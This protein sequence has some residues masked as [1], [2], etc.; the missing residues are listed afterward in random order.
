MARRTP[1]LRNDELNDSTKLTDALFLSHVDFAH[2][3]LEAAGCAHARGDLA[4]AMA[5]VVRHFRTRKGPVWPR[6]MAHSAWLWSSGRGS[7]V[8]RANLW[9][10]DKAKSSWFPFRIHAFAADND[11]RGHAGRQT[12]VPDLLTAYDETGDERYLV[13]MMALMRRVMDL[14]PFALHPDFDNRFPYWAPD[15]DMMSDGYVLMRWFDVLQHP[16]FRGASAMTDEF[17]AWML[18]RMWFQGVQYLRSEGSRYRD[19]NHHGFEY[20]TAPFLVGYALPE[21]RRFD[22]M[23]RFGLAVVRRHLDRTVFDDGAQAEHSV[24]YQQYILTKF[25]VPA[26]VAQANGEAIYSRAQNERMRKWCEF[27]MWAAKP[28]GWLCELGDH[29]PPDLHYFLADHAG[30]WPS[31][32]VKAAAAKLGYAKVKPARHLAKAWRATR[33]AKLSETSRHFPQGGYVVMRDGWSKD[34]MFM[35]VS[36]PGARVLPKSHSHFDPMHFVVHAFGRTLIGDPATLYYSWRPDHSPLKRGYHYSMGAHNCLVQNDDELMPHA[37]LGNFCV[38]GAQTP[39][40]SVNRASFSERLDFVDM[41]YDG[42]NIRRWCSTCGLDHGDANRHR[43]VILHLKGLGWVFVD[44]VTACPNDIRRHDFDQLLHFEPNTNA[45]AD[46]SR[47]LIH[48]LNDDANVLVAAA[49]SE[50]MPKADPCARVSVEPDPYMVT[51]DFPF[52]ERAPVVGHIRRKKID[53]AQFA[54]AVLP[55]RGTRPPEVSLAQS[56]LPGGMLLKLRVDADEYDIGVR[57]SERGRVELPGGL[58]ADARA[59]VV[60]RRGGR[61]IE[62]LIVDAGGRRRKP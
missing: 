16:A 57:L 48:T 44:R 24:P 53:D 3:G 60:R 50:T 21:F 10:E 26:A 14:L 56:D 19:D 11:V 31:G 40:V 54:L 61:V 13:K 29:V 18:K 20:G 36:T 25:A 7:V 47:G 2:P 58:A 51:S 35:L 12:F 32:F 52:G 4:G 17:R 38:W 6:Y 41:H 1:V 42:Y 45:R 5:G 37:A 28:D 15:Y 46:E 23:K 43:R 30:L 39:I 27:Q 8:E 59:T 62:T 34:S 55:Y 49:S 9:I 33:P 22:R